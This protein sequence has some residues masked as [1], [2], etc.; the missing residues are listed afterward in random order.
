MNMEIVIL[1][2]YEIGNKLNVFSWCLDSSS[3]KRRRDCL[4]LYALSCVLFRFVYITATCD[5]STGECG[6]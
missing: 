3:I 6:K 5:A 1:A 2:V 4:I